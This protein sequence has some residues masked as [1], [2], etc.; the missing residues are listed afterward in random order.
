MAKGKKTGGRQKGTPNKSTLAA[1]AIC[2]KHGVDLFEASLLLAMNEPDSH[3]KFEKFVAL[4]PYT[5]A[6]LSSI[7]VGVDP[8]KNA[9]KVVIEDYRAK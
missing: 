6:K 3:I 8:E 4:I 2:E 9:I 7:D 1:R 5:H